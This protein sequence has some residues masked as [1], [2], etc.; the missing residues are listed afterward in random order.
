MTKKAKTT[1]NNAAEME[2]PDKEQVAQKVTDFLEKCKKA[3]SVP[4]KELSAFF[5][6]LHLE[7]EQIDKFYETLDN[8][9]IEIIDEDF[10][11]VITED[12]LP[13]PNDLEEIEVLEDISEEEIK[14]R[15]PG[16]SK[17][18]HRKSKEVMPT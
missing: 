10:S 9:G 3:S 14:E 11:A 17:D 16:D 8:L 12:M 5:E 15:G 7:P 1:E 6:E 18:W 4:Y 2:K 13:E